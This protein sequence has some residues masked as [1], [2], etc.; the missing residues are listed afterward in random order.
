M[1]LTVI[2][3][4]FDLLLVLQR[5]AGYLVSCV[6]A[7]LAWGFGYGILELAVIAS[8]GSDRLRLF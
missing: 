5:T 7:L 6:N 4:I 3:N 8:R 2:Y 1:S